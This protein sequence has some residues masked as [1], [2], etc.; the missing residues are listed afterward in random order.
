[1]DKKNYNINTTKLIGLLALN[2]SISN[3]FPEIY[4]M[5]Y[6]FLNPL[7]DWAL[8]TSQGKEFH[9]IIWSVKTLIL[10]IY[11]ELGFG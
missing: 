2:M 10:Y 11:K 7:T 3:F 5:I 9:L 6:Q 4:S 8:I 1:M